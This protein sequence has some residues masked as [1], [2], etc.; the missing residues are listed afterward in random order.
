[1]KDSGLVT[2]K[3]SRA[4]VEVEENLVSYWSLKNE[5]WIGY[6]SKDSSIFLSVLSFFSVL[7]QK[8]H[9]LLMCLCC[10][11]P[12]WKWWL[13]NRSQEDRKFGGEI[14]EFGWSILNAYSL[15]KSKV[16]NLRSPLEMWIWSWGNGLGLELWIREGGV[17]Q[18][19]GSL[20]KGEVRVDLRIE[21]LERERGTKGHIVTEMG[22]MQCCGSWGKSFKKCDQSSMTLRRDR[23][24]K[25]KPLVLLSMQLIPSW[26]DFQWSTGGWSQISSDGEVCG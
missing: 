23:G 22:G 9:R 10:P 14:D 16:N 24:V 18:T 3:E 5:L 25:E 7:A 6:D 15:E 17:V 12:L 11:P 8:P 20:L 2:W 1:M 21:G 13:H 4:F 19:V 26:E